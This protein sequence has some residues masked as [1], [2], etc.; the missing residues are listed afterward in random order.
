V[1]EGRDGPDAPNV[2]VISASLAKTRW[3]NEDPIGTVIQ[4]GN[5]G[6]DMRP[7]T[8][9]GAVG[10]VREASLADTPRPTFCANYRQR[11]RSASAFFVVQASAPPEALV[12]AARRIV[13]ELRPDL[14]PRF[15]TIDTVVSNFVV[16]AYVGTQRRQEIGVRVALGAVA[17]V[18]LP[19]TS[20]SCVASDAL[21][22]VLREDTKKTPTKVP[23]LGTPADTPAGARR[24]GGTGTVLK[25]LSCL[26]G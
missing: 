20:C 22:V 6:V 5:M 24:P 12:P 16:I 23:S 21:Q 13:A 2:A 7:F 17:F 15:R 19:S 26:S 25:L 4:Y 8:I 10:D 11:P 3:P 9:V 14:P 1:F 18:D